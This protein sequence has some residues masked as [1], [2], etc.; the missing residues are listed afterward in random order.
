MRFPEKAR[1]DTLHRTRVL[2]LVGSTSHVVQSGESGREMSTPYFSGSCGP[3]VVSRK[4][5]PGLV[6]PNLCFCI[7]CDLWV[8]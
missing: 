7:R 8:T 3:S 4:S 2:H 6:V 5:A 1:L